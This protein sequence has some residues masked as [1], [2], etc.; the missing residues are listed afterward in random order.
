MKQKL[1][2]KTLLLLFALVAGSSSAWAQSTKTEGF[3]NKATA[4][5]YQG[6]V[7]ITETES[8]CGI[9]W[10]IYYGCVST[11]D[12]ISGSKSA[13]MRWYGNSAHVGNYPYIKTTTAIEGLSNVS[14][15]AR[16]SDKNV[17]MDVCYSADGSTWTVGKTHTFSAT[18]TGESVSLDIPSGNKYV[19]FGVSSTSTAPGSSS[20]YKLIVDDVVFTYSSSLTPASWTLTPASATVVEGQ[21]TKLQLTTDYDGTLTFTSNDTDVATVS[22]NSSKGEITVEGIAAGSTTI[23]VT[24]AATSTFEAIN[25]S[26]DVTVTYPE[27]ESNAVDVMGPLGYSYFGLTP[28]GSGTYV[29][30]DVTSTDKTDGYGVSISFA[31]AGSSNTKPRFDAAYMRLY[32]GNTLTVTAPA[33]A[34]LRKIVFTEPATGKSW[35]GSMTPDQGSYVEKTWYATTDD[36]TEVVFT[37]DGTKRIG[38]MEV[39][40]MMTNATIA[41]AKEFTTYVTIT[42]LDFSGVEGLKAYVATAADAS[43][44]T[45]EEPDGAVPAGTPLVL[46]KVSGTSFSVPVVASATAPV[47]NLLVAGDGTTSVGGD[48]V[49]DYILSGGLFYHVSPAGPVAVGKAYLH[50]DSAPGARE[51]TINFDDETAI[52]ALENSNKVNDGAIYDLSGRRV[53]NPTKGIY[54]MNG[55][56]VV[57]K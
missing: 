32:A 45:M 28:E 56:K 46:K 8:E 27:L 14:F 50:L 29:Q 44:V 36:V 37:D 4:T 38:G 22:Y 35:D 10:E 33:G 18:G 55:K 24:G 16:T 26:I 7:T 9:G 52:N 41:P 47:T 5:N 3:E 42:A 48:G 12:K 34:T 1:L 53:E 43:A 51:L 17:K 23:S 39:Y 13:Q 21:S 40:L 11:N 54:I 19:K 31:R 25:K 2:Q 6:T 57:I 30:P 15:K 49:W 20:N